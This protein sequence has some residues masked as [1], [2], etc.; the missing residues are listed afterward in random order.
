MSDTSAD[1][2][3]DTSIRPDSGFEKER[4]GPV[5]MTTR[6]VRVA[7]SGSRVPGRWIP[8]LGLGD[9]RLPLQRID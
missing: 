8:A 9:T 4:F 7:S 3:I 5:T 2:I 6:T 1:F